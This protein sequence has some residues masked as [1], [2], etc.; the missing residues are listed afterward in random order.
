M[1]KAIEERGDEARLAFA[2]IGVLMANVK[3][4]R[5]LHPT[6]LHVSRA[7]YPGD[8]VQSRLP[9]PGWL[10]RWLDDQ[11]RFDRTWEDRVVTAILRKMANLLGVPLETNRDL[12]RYRK[13][14]ASR[15][16]A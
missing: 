3:T 9:D 13:D 6:N 4:S 1:K 14:L 12:Q 5:A 7:L 10:E 11:I 2:K 8:T 16:A 15:M